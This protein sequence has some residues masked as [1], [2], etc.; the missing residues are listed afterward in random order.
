MLTSGVAGI[1]GRVIRAIEGVEAETVIPFI[2]VQI[3]EE[4]ATLQMAQG[5]EGDLEHELVSMMKS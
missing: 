4:A 2:R 1:A 3:I 5:S